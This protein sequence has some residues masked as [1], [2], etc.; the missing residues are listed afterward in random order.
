MLDSLVSCCAHT[1]AVVFVS[2]HVH[3]PLYIGMHSSIYVHYK[4]AHTQRVDT[5]AA[6]V[7]VCVYAYTTATVVYT[8]IVVVEHY[9]SSAC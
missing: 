7:Y 1:H 8:C 4:H 6:L 5:R 3:T 2:L 9:V